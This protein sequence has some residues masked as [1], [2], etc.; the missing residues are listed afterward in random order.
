VNGLLAGN[1][2][3]DAQPAHPQR[4]LAVHEDAFVVW[5]AVDN[6]AAHPPKGVLV[7]TQATT[8]DVARYAAHSSPPHEPGQPTGCTKVQ[9]VD[10]VGGVAG[11]GIM[12]S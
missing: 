7:W 3:D 10:L 11:L 4:Y 1:Q 9:G 5:A 2:V 6:R 8:R 12:P